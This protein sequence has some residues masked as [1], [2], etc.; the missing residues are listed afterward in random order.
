MKYDISEEHDHRVLT[1]GTHFHIHFI[2]SSL[3]AEAYQISFSPFLL[4]E[5]N[6]IF[7][8]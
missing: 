3:Y 7:K 1:S 2:E 8:L 6:L 4:W 5:W